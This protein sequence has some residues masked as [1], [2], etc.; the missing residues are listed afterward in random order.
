MGIL[1]LE[2][3]V[4]YYNGEFMTSSIFFFFLMMVL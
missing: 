1:S 4:W 3:E 2:K